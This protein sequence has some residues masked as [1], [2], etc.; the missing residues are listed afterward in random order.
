MNLTLVAHGTRKPAGVAMVGDLAAQAGALL[1]RRVR[2][3]FVDVLGPTP[4]E[5]L[6]S[7]TASDC[8]H[9]AIT[10]TVLLSTL[11]T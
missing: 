6:S 2:G 3:G 9:T 1:G 4:R 11:V 8:R 10:H 7:V 5:A